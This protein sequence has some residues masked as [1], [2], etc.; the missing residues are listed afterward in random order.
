MK[1]KNRATHL[2]H[3]QS[4]QLQA[5]Y[6]SGHIETFRHVAMMGLIEEFY[7]L[8]GKCERIKNFP[9]PRQYASRSTCERCWGRRIC[10][11]RASL[12]TALC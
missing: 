8:Q 6:E 3:N 2:L 12:S 4:G 5:L 10:L 7:T 11:H 1:R 9:L